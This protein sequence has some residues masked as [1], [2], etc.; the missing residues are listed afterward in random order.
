MSDDELCYMSATEALARFRDRSLS[1]VELTA[2]VIQRAEAIAPTVNPMGDCYFDEAMTRARAAEAKY[3]KPGGRPRRLEGLPLA[4]KD[5]SSVRGQRSANGSMIYQDHIATTT[6][7]AIARLLRAGANLFARTTCPEFCWL[8]TTHSRIWGV[9]RNPWRLDVTPGGS[10]GGSAAALAAGATTIATGGDS[11]GSIRQPASQCGVVGY[12]PPYGRY[13]LPAGASFDPYGQGGPM[14]R[15][16][17]DAARMSNIMSGPD[18]LDH[19]ALTRKLTI[20]A[21]PPGVAGM[22]IAVSYDLGHYQVIDEVRRETRAALDALA[23]AGAEIVEVDLGDLSE[24]IRLAHGA[25]EFVS[26]GAITEAV[27]KHG[28]LVSDYVPELARTAQSFSAD[29]Y[30]RG[31]SLAGEVWRDRLGSMFR[32]YNAFICPTVS[33]PEV[34]AENWQQTELMINGHSLTDTDTAMTALFNMFSRCPVLA[35]PS[36]MTD[37][38]LPTGIQIVGRPLDDPAVFRVAHA[39]ERQRPWLNN[40][41]RRPSLATMTK[42]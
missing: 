25:Q 36:G 4:V 31:L 35:V 28:N 20:P 29:G 5:S 40:P 3:A 17:A 1:P 21:D 42:L 41:A 34:P 37:A 16:V 13:P 23:D 19:T 24:T 2:A 7:T 15:T 33:C 9:T 27:E 11:T 30:R 14:T 10:S 12:K 26:A 22:R 6:D 38:G 8:F 39:L 32:E 18:P